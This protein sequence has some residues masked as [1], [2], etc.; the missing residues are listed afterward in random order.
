MY[1][2]K[3][4]VNNK[5]KYRSKW[6]RIETNRLNILFFSQVRS[7]L[8]TTGGKLQHKLY[9]YNNY[10]PFKQK[11]LYSLDNSTKTASKKYLQNV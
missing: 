2:N 8:T 7:S 3:M 5:L 11:T 1:V 4:E 9:I 10:L 6:I